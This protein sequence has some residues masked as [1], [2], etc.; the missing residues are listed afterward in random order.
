M[1]EG[2]RELVLEES[3]LLNLVWVRK[4]LEKLAPF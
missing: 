3:L 4:H 1:E 2:V